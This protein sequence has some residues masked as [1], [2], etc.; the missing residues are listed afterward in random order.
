[1]DYVDHSSQTRRL[2]PPIDE[3]GT[4]ARLD[5]YLAAKFPFLSRSGWQRQIRSGMVLVNKLPV[6][7][8]AQ[9]LHPGDELCRI[10]PEDE[11]PEV[12]TG[13]KVLWSDG[14]V[15]I[16]FKPSCLPMHEGGRYR[17]KTV[18]AMLPYVL[19]PDW[20]YV[21]RLDRETSGLLVCG[22]TREVR[23]ALGR[24]WEQQ[25]VKKTYLAITRKVPAEPRWTTRLPIK[26]SRHD[27]S[28]RAFV[29]A[30]GDDAVTEFSLVSAGTEHALIEA[31]PLT[32]RMNQIRVHCEA[33]GIPLVGDKIYGANPQIATWYRKEGN[34]Q[35]VQALAGFPRH[36][37]H[38]WK[39][40]LQHPISKAP[41]SFECP[42]PEDLQGYCKMHGIHTPN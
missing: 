15:A 4:G 18:A 37:L 32:G 30:D 40:Q 11:E 20:S 6:K 9:R 10:S 35:R 17:L 5:E 12:D 19:G 38:A 42:L 25:Q 27:R 26:H 2:G 1:M 39:I 41:L 34:S 3:Q 16:L 36:A 31:K 14:D 13:L 24:Q 22:R 33:L 28:N 7:R 21:H 29:A 8:P 23:E